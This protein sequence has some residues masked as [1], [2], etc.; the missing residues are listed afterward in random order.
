M[1]IY[2]T[3]TADVVY[4]TAVGDVFIAGGAN[5]ADKHMLTPLGAATSVTDE[6]YEALQ[7]VEVFR[8]HVEHGFIKADKHKQDAE[9]VA[10]EMT[11]RDNS[12][13]DTPESLVA[14][15]D[16]IES[17]KDGVIKRKAK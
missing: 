15:D 11:G 12:A 1:Y 8:T 3:L 16:T 2:S 4:T 9:K 13:P 10:T 7:K 5:I 6:Q 14:E 17:I